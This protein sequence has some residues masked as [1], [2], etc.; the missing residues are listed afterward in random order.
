MRATL[1][2]RVEPIELIVVWSGDTTSAWSHGHG[3]IL[4][5]RNSWRTAPNA[6]LDFLPTKIARRIPRGLAI[7]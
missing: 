4:P 7:E 3:E 5:P 6:A 2:P 1:R